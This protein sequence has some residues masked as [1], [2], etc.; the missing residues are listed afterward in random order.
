MVILGGLRLVVVV[1]DV[2]GTL[3][4]ERLHKVV[5]HL[6]KRIIQELTTHK[7]IQVVVVVAVVTPVLIVHNKVVMVVQ[8]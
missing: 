5:V 6:V 8:V 4:Q 2:L 7:T 1:V 3:V